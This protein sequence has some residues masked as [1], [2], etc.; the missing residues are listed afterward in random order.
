VGF[1]PGLLVGGGPGLQVEGFEFTQELGGGLGAIGG[2]LLEGPEDQLLEF[3]RDGKLCAFAGFEGGLGDVFENEG[4]RRRAF[5]DRPA[6]EQEVNDAAEG[7]EIGAAIN[8]GVVA[9]GELW[10]HV[11]GGADGGC[12]HGELGL[13]AA[14]A[15]GFDEAEVDNFDEVVVEAEAG[16]EDVGRFDVAVGEAGAVGFFEGAK[17][18]DPD[19]NGTG[20]AGGAEAGDELVEVETTDEFHGEIELAAGGGTEVEDGNG[21]RAFETGDDLGF[22]FEAFALDG[23]VVGVALDELDGG[24]AGEEAVFGLPDFSHAAVADGFDELVGAEVAGLFELGAEVEDPAGE[25]GAYHGDDEGARGPD[26]P[27]LDRGDWVTAEPDVEEE[28]EGCHGG[29]GEGRGESEA[30]GGGGEEGEEANPDG[31]GGLA[32]DEEIVVEGDGGFGDADEEARQDLEG[33]AEADD[34]VGFGG[35]SAAGPI[36]CQTAGQAHD[37]VHEEERF[38]L[39]DEFDAGEVIEEI[40]ADVAGGEDEGGD[41]DA[42]GGEGGD[43]RGEAVVDLT[44]ALELD[45]AFAELWRLAHRYSYY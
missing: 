4:H 21:V 12:L 15:I 45:A 26:E 9:F 36:H 14:E 18:A 22:A 39:G 17:D 37:R 10:S 3:I 35:P 16:E 1:P 7:V 31:D 32:A 34:E 40:E 28:A 27:D 30:E 13:F 2:G 20:G 25:E 24:V 11:G 42:L 44:L 5:K 33:E 43:V 41:T 23:G 8:D 6:S 19:V 38:E 29:G